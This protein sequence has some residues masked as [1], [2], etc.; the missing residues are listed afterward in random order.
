MNYFIDHYRFYRDVF[1]TLDEKGVPVWKKIMD[2]NTSFAFPRRVVME[3]YDP[4]YTL[5][6]YSVHHSDCTKGLLKSRTQLYIYLCGLRG[7]EPTPEMVKDVRDYQYPFDKNNDKY[8]DAWGVFSKLAQNTSFLDKTDYSDSAVIIKLLA[9]FSYPP[10]EFTSCYIILRTISCSKNERLHNMNIFYD[11][12]VALGAN[13]ED[14]IVKTLKN[15]AREIEPLWDEK[16][17]MAL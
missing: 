15:M 6:H 4:V 7:M 10:R 2:E 12:I 9:H 14:P 3:S 8:E 11:T 16:I 17:K 5:L 13:V 1:M